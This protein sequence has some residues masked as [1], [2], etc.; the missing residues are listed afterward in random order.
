MWERKLWGLVVEA[1]IRVCIEGQL[2]IK[3]SGGSFKRADK[4]DEC[5]KVVLW[6]CWRIFVWVW[7]EDGWDD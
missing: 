7:G 2:D 3:E 5:I 4:I 1:K 6:E